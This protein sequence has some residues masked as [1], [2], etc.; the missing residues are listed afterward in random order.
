MHKVFRAHR[1][2]TLNKTSITFLLNA[3]KQILT[4]LTNRMAY[5]I[6][7]KAVASSTHSNSLD[8]VRFWFLFLCLNLIFVYKFW[9]CLN[10]KRKFLIKS[11]I[12]IP[13]H[14]DPRVTFAPTLSKHIAAIMFIFSLCSQDSKDA[15]HKV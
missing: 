3:S 8:A 7:I 10:T 13:M 14:S 5:L 11:Y 2:I 6:S 1:R 4:S 15:L 9:F 12:C